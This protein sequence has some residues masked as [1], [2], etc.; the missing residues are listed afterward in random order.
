M[1]SLRPQSRFAF[2]ASIV[3]S[4]SVSSFVLLG[5]FDR[6]SVIGHRSFGSN[7]P[8]G[9]HARD[10]LEYAPC[11][12]RMW[13]VIS[14]E[15]ND[16]LAVQQDVNTLPPTD[17]PLQQTVPLSSSVQTQF[18]GKEKT[19]S[20]APGDGGQVGNGQRESTC[21]DPAT[22]G[23]FNQPGGSPLARVAF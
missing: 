13:R 9:D 4:S 21:G 18:F 7:P 15:P 3:L 11:S 23:L 10:L 8:N 19:A 17:L 6:G 20:G 2:V 12:S 14:R 5:F 1:P 16:T 22:R